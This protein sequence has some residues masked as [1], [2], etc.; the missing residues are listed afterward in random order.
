MAKTDKEILDFLERH[1]VDWDPGMGAYI[2]GFTPSEIRG[3]TLREIITKA[4][5]I[6]ESQPDGEEPS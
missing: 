2:P 5:D 3:E 6:E 4:I 1:L